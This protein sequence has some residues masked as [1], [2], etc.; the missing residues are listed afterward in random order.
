MKTQNKRFR[1]IQKWGNSLV[2][3]LTKSDVS[4]LLIKENDRADI[5]DMII[6]SEKLY[7]LKYGDK[8]E[9]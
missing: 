7:N 1:R 3:V 2:I 9:D 8:N 6:L 4:D 5:S